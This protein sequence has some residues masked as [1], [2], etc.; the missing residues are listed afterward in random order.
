MV[1]PT[2]ASPRIPA[3]A[4]IPHTHEVDNAQERR[5]HYVPGSSKKAIPDGP[6]GPLTHKRNALIT[7]TR[8]G[9]GAASDLRQENYNNERREATAGPCCHA[10]LS[11]V[12]NPCV[13]VF[14]FL[15]LFFA[16]PLHTKKMY[17]CDACCSRCCDPGGGIR[18]GGCCSLGTC[19]RLQTHEAIAGALTAT[20]PLRGDC[21]GGLDRRR[22]RR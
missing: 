12:L 20:E 5:V 3:S 21:G 14:S 9:P 4:H 15:F 8:W 16:G 11:A 1:A 2:H 17:F 22:R 7:G 6:S 19:R 13:S 18:G 10:K